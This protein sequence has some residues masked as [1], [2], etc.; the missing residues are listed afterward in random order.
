MAPTGSPGQMPSQAGETVGAMFRSRADRRLVGGR[1]LSIVGSFT[2]TSPRARSIPAL[3]SF[4]YNSGR[5]VIHDQTRGSSACSAAGWDPP[6][7]Q[8]PGAGLGNC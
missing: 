4:D 8:Q 1:E 7:Q 3:Q 6:R 2:L 5:L